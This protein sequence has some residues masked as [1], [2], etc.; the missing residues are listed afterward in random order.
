MLSWLDTFDMEGKLL[1]QLEGIKR[2]VHTAIGKG[3]FSG[4]CV[5]TPWK[6]WEVAG[7]LLTQL[8]GISNEMSLF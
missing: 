1:T 7:K 8:E 2:G 6:G 3:T 4:G 5:L